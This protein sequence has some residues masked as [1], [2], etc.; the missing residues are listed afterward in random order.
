MS[1]QQQIS[2]KIQFKNVAI[3]IF[4]THSSQLKLT[5]SENS[6]PILRV[7]VMSTGCQLKKIYLEE[8]RSIGKIKFI[9]LQYS[10]LG[11]H[12]HRE[13][14]EHSHKEILV[15]VQGN[16]PHWQI[17]VGVPFLATTHHGLE[18]LEEA[19]ERI[20]HEMVVQLNLP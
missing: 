2:K 20:V 19:V 1:N 12:I 13:E 7:L 10:F 14:R 16:R 6:G 3:S 8:F 5:Q 11:S 4:A 17:A 9:F 15:S 18:D